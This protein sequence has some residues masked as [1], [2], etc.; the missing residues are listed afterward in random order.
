MYIVTTCSIMQRGTLLFT[1]QRRL[2]YC[3]AT[4]HTRASTRA[5]YL[6]AR[7][8]HAL[9]RSPASFCYRNKGSKR[10]YT[11]IIL[12]FQYPSGPLHTPHGAVSQLPGQQKLR[13]KPSTQRGLTPLQAATS[14]HL[15]C[16]RTVPPVCYSAQGVPQCFYSAVQC[17]CTV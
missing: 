10:T 2:L 17:R 7:L 6:E 1:W 11:F 16:P 5:S 12:R 8:L 3:Q 13:C 15:Q 4:L 14:L 9:L